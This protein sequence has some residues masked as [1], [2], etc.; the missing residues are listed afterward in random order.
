M[1]GLDIMKLRRLDISCSVIIAL[2]FSCTFSVNGQELLEKRSAKEFHSNFDSLLSKAPVLTANNKYSGTVIKYYFVWTSS[3]ANERVERSGVI[4]FVGDSVREIFK[5]RPFIKGTMFEEPVKV[6]EWNEGQVKYRL[7]KTIKSNLE[8][9]LKVNG[10]FI[11]PTSVNGKLFYPL[12]V[13]RVMT[14]SSGSGEIL[15]F[16]KHGN[17]E[18]STDKLE[19]KED[20]AL[21]FDWL[22]DFDLAQDGGYPRMKLPV[23]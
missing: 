14:I 22:F 5:M 6:N 7:N 20:F 10:Y 12:N 17:K 3:Y 16:A 9:I 2:A 19:M 8:R 15:G 1:T 21:F 18:L 4:T 13:V 11:Q 23:K